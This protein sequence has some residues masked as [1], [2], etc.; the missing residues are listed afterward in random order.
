MAVQT[1]QLLVARMGSRIWFEYIESDS[2]WADGISR[3][4]V[5][6]Q[7]ALEHGF[8]NKVVEVPVW[9][10]TQPLTSLVQSLET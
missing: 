9:P 4:G 5:L 7:W 8:V 6:D 1:L 10:W 3:N 2:N